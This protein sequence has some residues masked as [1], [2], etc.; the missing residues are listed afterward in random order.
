M[1]LELPRDWKEMQTDDGNVYYY[2]DRVGAQWGHPGI[3]TAEGW[4]GR[5]SQKEYPGAIYYYNPSTAEMTWYDPRWPPQ[6]G[7]VSIQPTDLNQP[8]FYYNLDTE[9]TQWENPQKTVD[10]TPN[11]ESIDISSMDW[12]E[13]QVETP[14]VETPQVGEPQ[15]GEPQ[16]GPPKTEKKLYSRPNCDQIQG[17]QHQNNSCYIDSVLMAFFI[18]PTTFTTNLLSMD[19]GRK[20]NR[21][22]DPDP[23]CGN[24]WDKDLENRKAVQGELRSI[25]LSLRGKGPHVKTCE[26][27]RD[28]LRNCPHPENFWDDKM[29]SA[30]EFLLY[31]LS[32]FPVDKVACEMQMVYGTNNLLTKSI[33][34]VE[35]REIESGIVRNISF[36]DLI[37]QKETTT[38]KDYISI[39]SITDMTVMD[40]PW[41]QGYNY[42]I[43]YNVLKSSPY[44][45][46]VIERLYAE[47]GVNGGLENQKFIDV[48]VT[49]SKNIILENDKKFHLTA[50]VLYQNMHY[51]C[52][53]VCDGQWY[54][55][56]DMRPDNITKIGTYDDMLKVSPSPITNAT[57][58]FYA[59]SL[60]KRRKVS[61]R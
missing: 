43:D 56:D 42:K 61:K 17:L 46:F 20:G 38:T 55:Y 40:P 50:L 30:S 22:S 9:V 32:L 3:R 28:A 54:Y 2:N 48:P 15:V 25:V 47:R 44:I 52:V 14:Q 29:K 37:E 12:E 35:P 39:Y 60:P 21:L 19:L 10:A 41:N 24:S 31:L 51:T 59:P 16:V 11:F 23:R 18:T 5:L 57:L 45:I 53:F 27:L 8:R 13:P 36:R 34:I 49:P 58:V 26:K 1:K 6:Y 33:P 7:W 4:Y